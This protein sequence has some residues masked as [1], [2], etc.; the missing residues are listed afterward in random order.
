MRQCMYHNMAVPSSRC[1]NSCAVGL[2]PAGEG[3]RALDTMGEPLVSS[4]PSTLGNR[5]SV[6]PT[7]SLETTH[8]SNCYI[9]YDITHMYTTRV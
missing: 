6:L 2:L 8:E 4:S 7:P 3:P 5:V 1:N 9:L